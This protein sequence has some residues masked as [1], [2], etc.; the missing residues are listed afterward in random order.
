MNDMFFFDVERK[1]EKGE[2]RSDDELSRFFFERVVS[3]ECFPPLFSL[4]FSSSLHYVLSRPSACSLCRAAS[5]WGGH[6][7]LLSYTR[8]RA[9]VRAHRATTRAKEERK[10]EREKGRQERRLKTMSD[11]VSVFEYPFLART[12]R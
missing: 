9:Y 7:Q 4:S 2:E 11:R 3:G 12:L 8:A 5:R 6:E 10:T 1:K